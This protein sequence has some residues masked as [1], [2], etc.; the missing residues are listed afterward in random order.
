MSDIM[1]GLKKTWLK[2]VEAIGNAASNIAENAKYKVSEMN[3][4]TRRREILADFG[5]I[6]YEMWQR[7]AT[8]PPA[9]QQQL[10]QL[11]ALD[12]QL[13]AIRAQRIA[14]AKEAKLASEAAEAAARKTGIPGEAP[15][16]AEAAPS[17]ENA[18][19]QGEDPQE[20]REETG[21]EENSGFPSGGPQ[22]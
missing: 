20:D 10:Q 21:T 18:E 11:S 6:A 4:E 16:E 2:G 12:E 3:L 1:K 8:F 13:T 17:A 14:A 9:L 7:G 15:A 5:S 19:T 22:A